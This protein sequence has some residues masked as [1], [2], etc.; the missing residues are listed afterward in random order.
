KSILF[1]PIEKVLKNGMFGDMLEIYS[2]AELFNGPNTNFNAE[3]VAG[4]EVKGHKVFSPQRDGFEF[5]TLQNALS[6]LLPPEKIEEAVRKIIYSWDIISINKSDVV[7]ARMDEPQDPGVIHEI[8]IA[9]ALDVPVITYRT[10]VRSPYG[11][12]MD[13]YGGMH[14]F[15]IESSVVLIRLMMPSKT[16]DEAKKDMGNLINLLDSE[17]MKIQ[18]KAPNQNFLNYPE[19]I[20]RIL[21]IGK[22]LFDGIDNIHSQEGLKEIAKRYLE[23]SGQIEGFGPRVV[24]KL[25]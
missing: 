25:C 11:S 8:D 16:L 9:Q 21:E 24:G 6:E 4:L 3:V 15:P 23:N 1:F 19:N 18:G 10:D 2:A 13:T 20:Q 7:I 22:I 14:T 5:T 17:L 12:V